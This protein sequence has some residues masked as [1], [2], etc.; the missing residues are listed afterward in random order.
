MPGSLSRFRM[1]LGNL[2]SH[3]I[4]GA[5]RAEGQGAGL[6]GSGLKTKHIMGTRAYPL[7]RYQHQTS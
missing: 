1:R 5:G 3:L 7:L 6:T 4:M 2:A